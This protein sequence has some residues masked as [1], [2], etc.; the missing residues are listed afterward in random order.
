MTS[1]THGTSPASSSRGVNS[2]NFTLSGTVTPLSR[3][4]TEFASCEDPTRQKKNCGEGALQGSSPK[5]RFLE[6]T[7]P[8]REKPI[9]C[10]GSG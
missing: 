8:L 2:T 3:L 10:A 9:A 4:P 7:N 1:S 5:Q 6:R